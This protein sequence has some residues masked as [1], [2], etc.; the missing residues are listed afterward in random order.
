MRQA[1]AHP[2]EPASP[3]WLPSAALSIGLNPL[4]STA[5]PSPLKSSDSSCLPAD[6]LADSR[7]RLLGLLSGWQRQLVEL[8]GRVRSCEPVLVELELTAAVSQLRQQQQLAEQATSQLEARMAQAEREHR[9][10]LARIRRERDKAASEAARVRREKEELSLRCREL[11][12]GHM[13]LVCEVERLD[14]R[15]DQRDKQLSGLQSE[16]MAKTVT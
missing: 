8:E 7:S 14:A 2:P 5:P 3:D 12:K 13:A 15:E 6:P 10:E 16:L 1:L 4:K 9:E 11:E